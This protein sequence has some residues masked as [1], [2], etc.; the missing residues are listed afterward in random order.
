ME[1]NTSSFLR[2]GLSIPI[3]IDYVQDYIALGGQNII[4]GSDAHQVEDIGKGFDQ[5]SFNN[6]TI[7]EGG[8]SLWD[9]NC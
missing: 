7:G 3:Q 6:I 9:R 1:V 4:L 8:G 5:L 2:G